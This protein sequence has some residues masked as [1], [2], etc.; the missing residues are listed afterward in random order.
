MSAADTITSWILA[1]PAIALFYFAYGIIEEIFRKRRGPKLDPPK[2][3]LSASPVIEK[4]EEAHP[5]PEA[6]GY[7]SPDLFRRDALLHIQRLNAELAEHE[8]NIQEILGE[9]KKRERRE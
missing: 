7:D 5:A 4:T 9:I 1:L 3:F 6:H 8:R 2:P